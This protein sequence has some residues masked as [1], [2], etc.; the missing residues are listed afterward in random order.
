VL[1]AYT[2]KKAIPRVVLAVI[3]INLSIYL[4]IAAIDITTIVGRGLHG[5]LAGPFIE[6]DSFQKI[7]IEGNA[8]NEAGFVGVMGAGAMAGA[9]AVFIAGIG[10]SFVGLLFLLLPLIITVA[11]IALAV[12]FTLII[13]QGLLIFLTIISPV[14]IVCYILP[15]TEKYFKQWW[16]LFLKTLLVY[17]IIAAIFAMSNVLAAIL[18]TSA[19]NGASMF[20]GNY[21]AQQTDSMEAMMI[22]T[23]IIVLY[24]PLVLI[25]FAFKLA[26]GAIA[27]IMNVANSRASGMAGGLGQRIKRSKEDP[28]SLAGKAAHDRKVRRADQGLTGR[29]LWARRP[30][31]GEKRRQRIGAAKEL[32]QFINREASKET[33]RSKLNAQDSDIQDSLVMSAAQVDANKRDLSDRLTKTS[34]GAVGY[35]RGEDG[36]ITPQEYERKMR[37]HALADQMG[38]TT[39][40]RQAA[41][42]NQERI[43]FSDG[44][45]TEGYKQELDL[46]REIF[47]DDASTA[48]AMNAHQAI[49]TG[50]GRA[51]LAQALYGVNSDEANPTRGS[52]KAGAAQIMQ[53]HEKGVSGSLKDHLRVIDDE[54]ATAARKTQAVQFLA[55]MLSSAASPYGGGNEANKRMVLQQRGDIEKAF[56]TFAKDEA[57]QGSYLH[58]DT[59]GSGTQV[60]E[61]QTDA[62]GRTIGM[63]QTVPGKSIIGPQAA[64]ARLHRLSQ[65]E[66]DPAK[67]NST[68]EPPKPPGQGEEK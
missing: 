33:Y 17:P 14:A 29:Q 50:V 6:P 9:Y 43:K 58:A 36:Y 32:D 31:V 22:L 41:F 5:L 55:N 7:N 68:G 35:R 46:A 25:P 27:A 26:G 16:D 64:L 40:N 20:P 54:N 65:A 61:Q 38:R 42:L 51:D 2:V 8:V 56:E 23:A 21:F 37:S 24:L 62:S 53:G 18:L 15:G 30:G 57:T 49:A 10:A 34:Q 28:N 13:R 66:I 63:T 12:L 52:A 19:N 39:A 48:S 1:D 45:G 59:Q 4:C 44:E 47:D 67:T 60:L 3:A 11:L